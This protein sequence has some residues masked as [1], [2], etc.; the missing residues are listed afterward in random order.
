MKRIPD[1]EIR[2]FKEIKVFR[3]FRVFKVFNELRDGDGNFENGMKW[4][5]QHY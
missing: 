2:E 4:I 3:G 5:L 1:R